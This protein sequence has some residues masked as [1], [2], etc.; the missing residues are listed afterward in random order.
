MIPEQHP[1]FDQ[2]QKLY[3]EANNENS[4]IETI[5]AAE[6]Y[7]REQVITGLTFVYSSD[8]RVRIGDCNVAAYEIVLFARDNQI[9]GL[10]VAVA[11]QELRE[12]EFDI[13]LNE[14]PS[15]EKLRLSISLPD[16]P[17]NTIRYD[18]RDVWCKDETSADTYERVS[19]RDRVYKPPSESRLVGIYVGSQSF[20]RVGALYAPKLSQ[21]S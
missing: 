14:H 18:W 6:A 13:K 5:V 20:F 16:E 21:E 4:Y 2:V 17:V 10:P 11:D 12:I 15:S 3:F 7:L 9:V 1:P 8:R 19:L